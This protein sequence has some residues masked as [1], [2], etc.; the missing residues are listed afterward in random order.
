MKRSSLKN[1]VLLCFATFAEAKHSLKKLDLPQDENMFFYSHPSC[2]LL[3]TEIGFYSTLKRL[4]PILD[5]YTE[6]YSLG[7][8][9]ALSDTLK[10][11]TLYSIASCHLEI[12]GENIDT[13]SITLFQSSYP[14]IT[15]HSDGKKLVSSL[16]P[17]HNQE[18]KEKWY[19]K[20]HDLVD[21]EG[22]FLAG[23]CQ[24][25]QKKCYIYRVVSDFC[26]EKGEKMLK[27]SLEKSSVILAEITSSFLT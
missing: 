20:G 9:G 21:M 16:V 27:N 6:V 26:L 3:I 18:I 2:D 10:H 7:V 1:K 22:Y 12:V 14:P 11:L 25:L 24:A 4:L 23:L 17:I 5:R 13:H 8:A 19:K 15:L